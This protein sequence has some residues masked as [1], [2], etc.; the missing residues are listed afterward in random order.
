V[1]NGHFRFHYDEN[2]ARVGPSRGYIP[3]NWKEV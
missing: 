2:L 1:M 3:V